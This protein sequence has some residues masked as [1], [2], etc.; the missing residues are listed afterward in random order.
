MANLEALW[1]AGRLR[2]GKQ[3]I[4]SKQA[5][6]THGRISEVLG[7]PFSPVAVDTDGRMDLVDIEKQLKA[8]DVG[9]IVATI[10]NT[11]LG[12]VDRLPEI[13]ELA[14]EYD[15]RVHADAAYGGYFGLASELRESTRATYDQLHGSAM[16][17]VP[18]PTPPNITIQSDLGHK[19]EKNL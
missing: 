4:A 14:A 8:G 10:G 6:Y 9:T 1:A 18:L 3:I 12:A 7:L 19:V 17:A 11:G 13:L 2:P 15:V 16:Q 5:H